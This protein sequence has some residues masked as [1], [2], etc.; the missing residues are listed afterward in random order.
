MSSYCSDLEG[1]ITADHSVIDIISIGVLYN[2]RL[3]AV[4]ISVLE[5]GWSVSELVVVCL[6][7][8]YV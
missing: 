8:I 3:V 5:S 4:I 1:W 6:S 7:A 2:C